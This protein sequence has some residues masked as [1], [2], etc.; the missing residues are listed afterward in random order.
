MLACYF[1][2][3]VSIHFLHDLML[4]R[5]FDCLVVLQCIFSLVLTQYINH[6]GMVDIL[7]TSSGDG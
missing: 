4:T 5:C 2:Y 7:L 1:Y 6:P 3:P